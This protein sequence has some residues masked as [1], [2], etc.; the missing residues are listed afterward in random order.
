MMMKHG[1]EVTRVKIMPNYTKL[2][3]SQGTSRVKII[4]CHCFIACL[5][6]LQSQQLSINIMEFSDLLPSKLSAIFGGEV[7]EPRNA[8]LQGCSSLTYQT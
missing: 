4:L 5:Q 1:K 7:P 6:V 2:P 8:Q 3:C